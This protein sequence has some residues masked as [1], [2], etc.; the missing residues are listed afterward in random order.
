MKGKKT[1][2]RLHE[3][4]V[5]PRGIKRGLQ[6][7]PLLILGLFIAA[8]V[9]V[10]AD[11][12]T[13]V[14]RKGSRYYRNS[15][16]REALGYFQEGGEKNGKSMVPP[17]NEGAALYKMEDYVRSVQALEEAL[18]KTESEEEI[19][20]IH[21]NLGN[22][23]YQLGSYDKAVEH[24]IKALE[25]DPNDLN[26]KF[27]LELA[28][29]KLSG[30]NTSPP[31]ETQEEKGEGGEQPT[32]GSVQEEEYEGS[33]ADEP[34]DVEY[35]RDEAQRLVDSVNNDQSRIINEIIKNRVGAAQNEK[36]W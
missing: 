8:P 4:S 26:T 13:S 17:F 30:Q 31:E 16:F 19:A 18:G 36:D 25:N 29:E 9:S 24:Y 7:M 35:S 1:M 12:Y 27:N 11:P 32:E 23:H 33:S 34:K 15:L 10:N 2:G 21:F 6:L 22:N 3:R 5:Y 20:Q 28:L 14:M